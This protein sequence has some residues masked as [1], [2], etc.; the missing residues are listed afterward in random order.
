MFATPRP[1]T[2]L[3]LPGEGRRPGHQ[4]EATVRFR[5]HDSP[6]HGLAVTSGPCAPRVPAQRRFGRLALRSR[7][8]TRRFSGPVSPRRPQ[9]AAHHTTRL[10][11]AQCFACVEASSWKRLKIAQHCVLTTTRS[12]TAARWARH[13]PP[14]NT[15]WPKACSGVVGGRLRC[16]CKLPPAGGVERTP[17]LPAFSDRT[18]QRCGGWLS[19]HLV[20]STDAVIGRLDQIPVPNDGPMSCRFRYRGGQR[21]SL[22]HGLGPPRN[23][24]GSIMRHLAAT[25]AA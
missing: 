16:V 2:C 23:P 8:P 25:M 14:S 4:Q 12:A 20:V 13:R 7:P 19:V 1:S 18:G 22:H 15:C 10:W 17:A 24:M 6:A 11:P 3:S 21:R 5:G 9:Q